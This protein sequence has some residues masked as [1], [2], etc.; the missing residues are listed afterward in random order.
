MACNLIAVTDAPLSMA[1]VLAAERS[2]CALKIFVSIPTVSI[3]V[4]IQLAILTGETERAGVF[5]CLMFARN[6]VCSGGRCRRM[7]VV[8]LQNSHNVSTGHNSSLEIMPIL[9]VFG[10]ISLGALANK[11]TPISLSFDRS[12]TNCTSRCWR[13]P[14]SDLGLHIVAR[15][16]PFTLIPKASPLRHLKSFYLLARICEES[17]IKSFQA[18]PLRSSWAPGLYANRYKNFTPV[19]FS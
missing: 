2:E 13:F 17:A 4:L 8:Y 1:A 15:V 11:V 16:I 12:K 6:N 9:D 14:M 3:W 5:S 10:L 19:F 7:L 18:F